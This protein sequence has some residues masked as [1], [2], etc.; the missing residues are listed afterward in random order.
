V[1]KE[2]R[3]ED[4]AGGEFAEF[5]ADVSQ[6]I[7]LRVESLQTPSQAA[8]PVAKKTPVAGDAGV[9]VEWPSIPDRMIEDMR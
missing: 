9:I 8:A 3:K 7:A 5:L 6:E 4:E 2:T 1:A